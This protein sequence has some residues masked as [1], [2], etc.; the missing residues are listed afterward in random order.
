LEVRE[1]NDELGA[2]ASKEPSKPERAAFCRKVDTILRP[3]FKALGETARIALWEESE[4][5]RSPFL[6]MT[7]STKDR[8]LVSPQPIFEEKI[9]PLANETGATRIIA[10]LDGSL[11]IGI[12]G[13]YRYWT[14]SRA[15]MLCAEI[16]RR[17][18]TIF[19][20]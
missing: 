10:E 7:I 18:F 3:F 17:H 4:R 19:E 11:V 2:R 8:S 16:I 9:L 1:P 6:L 12:L 20:T 5:N 14:P 15:R 13:Q